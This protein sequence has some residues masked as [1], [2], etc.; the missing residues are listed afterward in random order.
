MHDLWRILLLCLVFMENVEVDEGLMFLA[1][2]LDYI[3]SVADF[4]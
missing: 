2:S 1:L 3:P 4:Y